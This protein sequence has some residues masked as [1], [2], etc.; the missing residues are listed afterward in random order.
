[1][2]P[3]GLYR[4]LTILSLCLSAGALLLAAAAV[5]FARPFEASAA[6]LCSAVFFVPGLLFLN[7]WRR[8]RSRDLALA[9]AGSVADAEGVIDSAALGER[10]KVPKED[11]GKILRTA[12]REGH[13]KGDMDAAG[14]YVSSTA[15]RCPRCGTPV[16]R[17][18]AG[19]A[20]PSCGA[21]LAGG[22]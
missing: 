17:N 1:M 21:P 19:G 5:T 14:R 3:R 16:A 4:S 9:H 12:I 15:L 22:G 13:A 11:A 8:L 6:A 7:H 18:L 2:R 20:C 10:L